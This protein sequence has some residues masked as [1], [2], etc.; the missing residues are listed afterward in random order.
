MASAVPAIARAS[1]PIRS[2]VF[3]ASA[4]TPRN[5]AIQRACR[6]CGHGPVRRTS[7]PH[8]I[9][10]GYRDT[11]AAIERRAEMAKRGIFARLVIAVQKP[12]ARGIRSVYAARNGRWDLARP[13]A[14]RGADRAFEILARGPGAVLE[15]PGASF[16]AI[17]EEGAPRPVRVA[18]L[19]ARAAQLEVPCPARTRCRPV[20][21]V[22][23]APFDHY[24]ARSEL[25]IRS[26]PRACPRRRMRMPANTSA[27]GTFGVTIPPAAADRP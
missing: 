21:A 5:R 2:N 4:D 11:S 15:A 8:R 27:S 16:A 9:G 22:E 19:D 14:G 1:A 17:A 23:V 10:R 20:R 7:R 26:P 13:Q 25:R 24:D 18:R 3:T 12:R 6:H